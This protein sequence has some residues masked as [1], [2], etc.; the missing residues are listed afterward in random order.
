MKV[1]LTERD[2]RFRLGREDVARLCDG[3]DVQLVVRLG[4]AAPLRFVVQRSS[5]SAF[6]SAWDGDLF[7][8]GIPEAELDG[9][10]GD[11]REGFSFDARV[12]HGHPMTVLVQKNYPCAHVD[13][14]D[15]SDTFTPRAS[16]VER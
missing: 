14:E 3:Q 12:A 7:V 4:V 8:V 2:V 15:T 1:R 6:E 9:W 11:A 13:G 5:S 10:P 16:G